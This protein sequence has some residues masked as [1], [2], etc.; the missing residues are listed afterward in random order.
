MHNNL[1]GFLF[2]GT[3]VEIHPRSV[4]CLTLSNTFIEFKSI[5]PLSLAHLWSDH[6]GNRSN[7]QLNTLHL[8]LSM[9]R[10]EEIRSLSSEFCVCQFLAQV[11]EKT[12]KVKHPRD[13]LTGC[14]NN[15]CWLL[16]MQKNSSSIPSSPP[17]DGAAHPISKGEPSHPTEKAYFSCL[18]PGLCSLSQDPFYHLWGQGQRWTSKL[19]ALHVAQHTGTAPTLPQTRSQVC[20]PIFLFPSPF[21]HHS[22]ISHQDT[23][24]SGALHSAANYSREQ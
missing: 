21:Y 12:S 11:P 9:S 3:I 17:E 1:C 4:H 5:K 14:L 22:R 6:D 7:M 19:G 16:L 15:L 24:I 8:S 20:L 10:P 13:I 18:Y 2:L 23:L